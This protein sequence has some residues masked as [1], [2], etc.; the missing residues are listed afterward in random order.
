MQ[1]YKTR[2]HAQDPSDKPMFISNKTN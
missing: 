2:R 1:E